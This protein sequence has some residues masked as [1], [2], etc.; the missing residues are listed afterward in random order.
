MATLRKNVRLAVFERDGYSCR[1]CG[2]VITRTRYWH[3]NASRWVAL[4]HAD[5][6]IPRSKGGTDELANLVTSCGTCNRRKYNS[7]LPQG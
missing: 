2:G 4:I 7:L 3:E 5:H 1:Y 6:V